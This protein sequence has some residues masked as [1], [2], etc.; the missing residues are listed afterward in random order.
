MQTLSRS[1]LHQAFLH[2]RQKIARLMM[3]EA[4]AAV[5][6]ALHEI[7]RLHVQLAQ[8]VD[9]DMNVHVA[10]AL[11]T[12]RVR[13]DQ[14]LVPGKKALGKFSAERLRFLAGQTAFRHVLRIKAD[15]VVMRL[16]FAARLVFVKICV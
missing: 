15:D 6:Q 7:L 12:V 5:V 3:L 16:D 11:V 2:S 8:T 4:G 13:A 9:H 10:A 1:D 14:S